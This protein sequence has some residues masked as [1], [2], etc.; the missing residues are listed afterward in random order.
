MFPTEAVIK[1]SSSP[2]SR[3]KLFGQSLLERNIRLLR[4]AGAARIYLDLNE[5]DLQY[6]E[7]KVKKH[8]TPLTGIEIITG[9]AI[10]ENYILLSANHFILFSSFSQLGENFILL[11]NI[12]QP[13]KKANQFIIEDDIDFSNGRK[14]AMEVIRTGSGGKLAQNINKRISIP[15]SL[16]L[17]R[18]RV[19]PNVITVI[20]FLFGVAAVVLIASGEHLNQAIGGILVQVCSIVDGC[21]GEVA[22]MTTR[23]SKI[24]GFLDSLSD[25]L[26]A[27]ALIIVATTKVYTNFSPLIFWINMISVITGVLIMGGII[28]YFM[29]R[30]TE[31]MSYASY[32]RE[33]LDP[34]PQ[35]D[36]LA[37]SMRYLQYLA[38]KELYSM[39][40]CIFCLFG[41]IEYYMLFFTLVGI[42]GALFMLILSIRYFPKLKRIKR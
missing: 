29:R 13:V 10:P 39:L 33:F 31:S 35:S 22:R 14:I 18:L 42:F 19:L 28:T 27:A 41:A 6:Y 11:N 15:I 9:R 32:I 34:L 40:V 16:L 26:L 37:R 21:D 23:F 4:Q 17:A 8:I 30:Y 12:Y 5:S 36:Y 7:K 24:G 38:R 1:S 2:V 25:N 3:W 20:N